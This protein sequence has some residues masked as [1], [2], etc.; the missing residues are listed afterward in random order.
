M[1]RTEGIT[2]ARVESLSIMAD[3]ARE[4]NRFL[5]FA[6]VLAVSAALPLPGPDGRIAGMP[7]ICPFHA[8][9]GLPC[10]GCGLTRAFVCLGHGRFAESLVWH[11][12]GWMLFGAVVMICLRSGMRWLTARPVWAAPKRAA[13][14][15]MAV[16]AV[17]FVGVGFARMAGTWEARRNHTAFA[18]WTQEAR[19]S[20]NPWYT[21]IGRTL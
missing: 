10:P 14:C 4:R 21:L 16:A 8:A 20:A 3:R 19:D 2:R 18:P 7:S 13:R 9:T 1:L 11:P 12:L 15:A 5:F 6:A 17:L